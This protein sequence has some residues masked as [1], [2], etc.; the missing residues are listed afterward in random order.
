MGL[1][2]GSV[3]GWRKG[4]RELVWVGR[5]SLAGSSSFKE[6]ESSVMGTLE[7]DLSQ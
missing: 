1:V 4:V 3:V 6:R 5:E 7:R 2:E